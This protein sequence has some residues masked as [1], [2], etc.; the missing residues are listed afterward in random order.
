MTE[1]GYKKGNK[2]KGK[3]KGKRAPSVAKQAKGLWLEPCKPGAEDVAAMDARVLRLELLY[4]AAGRD[5]RDHSQHGTY[6]GLHQ[7]APF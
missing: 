5:R 1:A 6:A 4:H 3:G 7:A 2:G